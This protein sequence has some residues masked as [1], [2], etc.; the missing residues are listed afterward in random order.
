MSVAGR[1][2]VLATTADGEVDLIRGMVD[3]LRPLL[4]LVVIAEA[5]RTFRGA[6]RQV[7]GSAWGQALGLLPELIRPVVTALPPAGH[8]RSSMR[9]RESLQRAAIGLGLRGVAPDAL[10]ITVD[11]DEYVDPAW[12]AAHAAGIDQPTRLLLVPLYGGL[13]RR[14]PDWHCCRS[15]LRRPVGQWPPTDSDWLFPG[16]VIGPVGALAG[17][18]AADWRAATSAATGAEPAGWHLL[19]V[20]PAEGDPALKLARQAH[21]WDARADSQ[22]MYRALHLGVHPYGW[23]GA[24]AMG[25]PPALRRLAAAHPHTTRGTLP[26]MAERELFRAAALTRFEAA[27]E[28]RTT[29]AGA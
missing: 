8:P 13:D 4:D 22:W 7:V 27:G 28:H 26:P 24:T 21:D 20:L 15:H 19:H 11:S 23:W 12:L 3:L 5:N 1:P 9:Q 6:D 16:G 25:V 17:R 10:V 14:A 29:D 2:L 18:G